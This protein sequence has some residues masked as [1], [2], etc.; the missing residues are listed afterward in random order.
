MR[1]IYVPTG[2]VIEY[3]YTGVEE[4]S[5]VLIVRE[6]GYSRFYERD[7]VSKG[8]SEGWLKPVEDCNEHT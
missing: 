3:A 8:L 4:F 6:G 5:S 2:E 7:T 1:A